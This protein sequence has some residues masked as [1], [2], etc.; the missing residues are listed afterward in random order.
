MNI[1]I[2]T[3]KCDTKLTS[4]ITM[5]GAISRSF[6]ESKLRKQQFK[7]VYNSS[8]KDNYIE[9]VDFLKLNLAI[10]LNQLHFVL[11]FYFLSLY[12]DQQLYI[13]SHHIT[14]SVR[15]VNIK[16]S[17]ETTFKEI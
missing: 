3:K 13:A 14:F 2:I 4:K 17:F 1:C 7:Y 11:F 6:V 15:L 12:S 8:F 5:C 9:H 16:I 10:V